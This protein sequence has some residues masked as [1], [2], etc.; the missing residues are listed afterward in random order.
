MPKA[1]PFLALIISFNTQAG[2]GL[3]F[4]DD[5]ERTVKQLKDKKSIESD[6]KKFWSTYR[7]LGAGVIATSFLWGLTGAHSGMVALAM[8]LSEERGDD[9]DT[10]VNLDNILTDHGLSHL[11]PSLKTDRSIVEN[12]ENDLNTAIDNN[13]LDVENSE[14]LEAA[15]VQLIQAYLE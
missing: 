7:Y 14:E 11:I 13:E 4:L 9:L 3:F 2:L 5:I 10:I 8:I 15:T 6:K 12:I 1:H